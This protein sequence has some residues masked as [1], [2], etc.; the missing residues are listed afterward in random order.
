MAEITEVLTFVSSTRKRPP[1]SPQA[2][3][4]RVATRDDLCDQWCE[5]EHRWWA[6]SWPGDD[7]EAAAEELASRTGAAQRRCVLHVPQLIR[8]CLDRCTPLSIAWRLHSA[9]IVPL[10]QWVAALEPPAECLAWGDA[11]AELHSR[12]MINGDDSPAAKLLKPFS[13]VLAAAVATEAAPPEVIDGCVA[14]LHAYLDSAQT[15]EP[16]H[17]AATLRPATLRR[18]AGLLRAARPI[19]DAPMRRRFAASQLEHLVVQAEDSSHGQASSGSKAVE[20]GPAELLSSLAKAMEAVLARNPADDAALNDFAYQLSKS[21]GAVKLATALLSF[22][23]RPYHSI[24]ASSHHISKAHAGK[25]LRIAVAAQNTSPKV[26]RALLISLDAVVTSAMSADA[27]DTGISTPPLAALLTIG[28]ALYTSSSSSITTAIAA[29]EMIAGDD[30]DEEEGD[31]MPVVTK[32]K[33][34][35][36]EWLESLAKHACGSGGGQSGRGGGG[37][38]NGGESEVKKSVGRLMRALCDLVPEQSLESI[39]AHLRCSRALHSVWSGIPAASTSAGVSDYQ[40]LLRTRLSDLGGNDA[41]GGNGGE[42]DKAEEEKREARKLI[43]DALIRFESDGMKAVPQAL[44]RFRF[45]YQRKWAKHAAPYLLTEPP[46][47]P[48]GES[49]QERQRRFEKQRVLAKLI[50]LLREAKMLANVAPPKSPPHH[51][52]NSNNGRGGFTVHVDEAFV[53]KPLP[54]DW[55]GLLEVL[56]EIVTQASRAPPQ[57]KA[58]VEAMKQALDAM[59]GGMRPPPLPNAASSSSAAPIPTT[60]TSTAILPAGEALRCSDNKIS[61]LL[62]GILT[63]FAKC[64]NALGATRTHDWP[65]LIVDRLLYKPSLEWPELHKGLWGWLR[66][67]LLGGAGAHEM[68][69]ALLTLQLGSLQRAACARANEAPPPCPHCDGQTALLIGGA[70]RAKRGCQMD[71]LLSKL[72]P[73]ETNRERA[74]TMRFGSCY[75]DLATK[76]FDLVD[77]GFASPER[78]RELEDEKK[79]TAAFVPAGLLRLLRWLAQRD[80]ALDRAAS[81]EMAQR[82][83]CREARQRSRL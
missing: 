27:A 35:Y 19:T 21:L 50:H 39:R 23:P 33:G 58:P 12:A 81:A 34:S 77:V 54:T 6:T 14:V 64:L 7:E 45:M 53:N 8:A 20:D 59:S 30:D 67:A 10:L 16:P 55:L 29:D 25:W 73:M 5:H 26:A 52:S 74:W 22:A 72:L 66:V 40:E 63:A 31:D 76:C 32:P 75:L 78:W 46:P 79:E 57:L 71:A 61:T 70:S 1:P 4:K 15:D 47:P 48:F 41:A 2:C 43:D 51:G 24:T 18:A 28:Y 56:P 36:P 17:A 13:E 60:D 65:K 37:V 44:T 62:H 42:E 11:L 3:T 82:E 38:A 83:R 69:L 49:A 68:P 9:N 80:E